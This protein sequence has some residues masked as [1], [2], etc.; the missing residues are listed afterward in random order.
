MVKVFLNVSKEKQRERLQERID[1][2]EK[3]WKFRAD[4]LS[5]RRHFDDYLK[6]Y[7]EVLTE[8]STDWSP[9]HIVPAD[10]NWL[11]ALAVA[12]LLVTT[13]EKMDPQLPPPDPALDG[14]V[15]D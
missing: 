15:V 14:T 13:L 5:A 7:D 10:H 8:T 9:W 12:Q 3:R 2:P 4:D 11:K 1:N 6:A